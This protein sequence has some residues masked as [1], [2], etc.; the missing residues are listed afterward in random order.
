VGSAWTPIQTP[1]SRQFCCYPSEFRA[2]WAGSKFDVESQPIFAYRGR[3]RRADHSRRDRGRRIRSLR[4]SDPNGIATE[5]HSSEVPDPDND[6]DWASRAETI[7]AAVD[8]ITLGA[9]RIEIRNS[10]S[11]DRRAEVISIPW[12]PQAF[13]RTREVIGPSSEAANE[14][15]PIRAE[16]R[17]NFLSAITKG[18]R[19]LNEI[20]SAKSTGI[21][22]VA[23]RENI[24]ERS[25]RM[26]LSLAFLAPDIVQAAVDGT[27]PRG[28]GVSR[29]MD[30][31]PNWAYQR[32]AIGIA[33]S[34]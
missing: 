32:R 4:Q 18:R 27:L 20:V 6:P 14:A 11:P 9:G 8:R 10:E 31:P 12:S 33:S 17:R 23:A 29:L 16:A 22:A 5:A 3:R 34:R 15:R 24:S 21:E 13:R 2:V 26:A 1:E 7:V 25:V 28:L 19:W 30:L